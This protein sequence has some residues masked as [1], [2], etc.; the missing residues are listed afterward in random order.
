MDVPPYVWY[1]LGAVLAYVVIV[2]VDKGLRRRKKERLRGKKCNGAPSI[3]VVMYA[4]KDNYAAAATVRAMVEAATCPRRLR[5]AVVQAVTPTSKDVFALYREA[6]AYDSVRLASEVRVKTFK[7]EYPT[8]LQAYNVAFEELY[9]DED[10]VLI[11]S[12]GT[13][14]AEHFDEELV[15]AFSRRR[16]KVVVTSHGQPFR[17][18]KVT[19]SKTPNVHTYIAATFPTEVPVD[20]TVW[21]PC[22]TD[23]LRVSARAA[24]GLK[25][26]NIEVLGCSAICAM[27][28]GPPRPLRCGD[29]EHHDPSFLLS[30]A[31]HRDDYR[32]YCPPCT[33]AFPRTTNP[34]Y[35][36][37]TVPIASPSPYY[38]F[39]G[40]DRATDECTGR[41]MLGVLPN[42]TEKEIVEK[43]G[44]DANYQRAKAPFD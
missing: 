38:E 22:Y 18:G 39:A 40:V 1:I 13:V 16:K 6:S 28:R 2:A 17:M 44:N 8:T 34:R 23:P 5:F 31:L 10:Y 26:K 12:P 7:D 4:R 25:K 20:R 3:L 37:E 43:Y 19:P 29:E 42:P 30:H 14:F 35:A 15:R 41:A 24:P 9:E 11:T 36:P 33:V 32:F 21:Y 27:F